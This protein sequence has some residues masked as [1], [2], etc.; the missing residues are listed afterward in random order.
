MKKNRIKTCGKLR[1]ALA[2][3]AG[4]ILLACQTQAVTPYVMS[5]GNYLEDFGDIA[6]WT[7]NFAGGIGAQYWTSVAMNATGAIPDGQKTTV[8]TASWLATSSASTGIEKGTN[9]AG[10]P[11]LVFLC[12]GTTDSSAAIAADL[13]LDFT[14][15]TA[16]SLSFDFAEINNSFAAGNNRVSSLRVYAT[17]DGLTYTE[18]PGAFVAVTNGVA[19]SGTK[20]SIVLPA[21]FSGSSTAQ[22]RFYE[23]NGAGG[24]SGS[25]PKISVDNVIVTSTGSSVTPPGITGI[26]PTSITTNAGSTVAFTVTASGD[27]LSYFWYKRSGATSNL[28]AGATTATL[29]LTNVLAASATNYSV[30][31]SN[32]V[33]TTNSTLVTLIVIDPA[34]NA[35][36]VASQIKFLNATANLSVTAGGTPA[37]SYQW[38]QGDPGTA[39]ALSNGGRISGAKTNA[40]TITG[41]TAA[42]TSDYFVTVGNGFGTVTSSVSALI[43]TNIN[44]VTKWDFN[45]SFNTTTPAA[46]IG[47]GTATLIGGVTGAS[48][49]GTTNDNANALSE[50]LAN[51][52]W[53]TAAYATN[54][55]AANNKT[56][57]V[58]FNTSTVGYRNVK[59]TYESRNSNT[60]SKYM[61]LQYT[62]N[63]TDFVD[64][65]GDAMFGN[66][67][68]FEPFSF[69]LTGFAGVRNNANFGFRLVSEY[70]VTANFGVGTNAYVAASG[71][72]SA[73][74]TIRYDLVALVAEV[75]TNANVPPTISGLADT[76]TM[77]STPANLNF[78]IGDAETAAASLTVTAVSK[79]QNVIPDGNILLGGSG[80]SRT[81]TLTPT[82]GVPGFAP[83]LVT[84]SD[85]DG[86]STA[87]LF[88]LTVTTNST[89]LPIPLNIQSSGTNVILTWANPAFSL[90]SATNVLGPYTTIPASTSPYTN[91][92]TSGQ[93][94]FRLIQ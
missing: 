83:I 70:E 52:G 67:G 93:S 24:L 82:V 36:P 68:N 45:G 27:A 61:R 51:N 5:N 3:C 2:I 49:T 58:Q 48:A 75:I 71:N 42:D 46:S 13:S 86:N 84:V 57:G 34:I 30:L 92:A 41:L 90:Q 7:A 77:D 26:S 11:N 25:R 15:R 22:I 9:T 32:S 20:S 59:V 39:T 62:T 87:A 23:Y 54:N 73:A 12:S 91:A 37:L 79:N 63:G 31:V 81:L 66:P 88:N 40:L 14:G 1:S 29:T 69:D 78:T 28:I 19:S 18:L 6:N 89:V 60:G 53:Q 8:A 65:P 85:P 47:T 43:V 33:A 21:A 4:T 50:G 56:S 38:Y 10:A 80:A 55:N 94:Y 76:S 74:G 72:F 44:A 16:G 35:Q 17:T 64:Y